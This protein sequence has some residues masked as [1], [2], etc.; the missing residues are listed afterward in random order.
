MDM[1]VGV[2]AHPVPQA[3]ADASVKKS[4][5]WHFLNCLLCDFIFDFTS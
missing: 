2:A 1:D 3:N 4:Q 5:L